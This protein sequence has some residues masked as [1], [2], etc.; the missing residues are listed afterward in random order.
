MKI[1]VTY[2]SDWYNWEGLPEF[3]PEFLVHTLLQER[4]F[5][6]EKRDFDETRDS[7]PPRARNLTFNSSIY[8][9]QWKK[10]VEFFSEFFLHTFLQKRRLRFEKRDLSV[11]KC[12]KKRDSRP[13]NAR[14]STLNNSI[15]RS[16][17]EEH[18]EFLYFECRFWSGIWTENSR[19]N[20]GC[21]SQK[22]LP[23]VSFFDEPA[24]PGVPNPQIQEHFWRL[25][26]RF[27]SF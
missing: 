6:L 22:Y 21:I 18:L 5:L 2:R 14:N 17:W 15:D 19:K 26:S 23:I 16:Q 8:R 12:Q 27:C 11:Q 25:E 1:S 9:S 20:P 7:G 13:S 3:F 24:P 4:G 10:H